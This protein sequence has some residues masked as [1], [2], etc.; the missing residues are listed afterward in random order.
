MNEERISLEQL[1][2]DN[3]DLE[4]LESLLE[5][6]NIFEVLGAVRQEVRHSDFLAFL[7]DPQQHHG[8]GG[9]FVKRFL[10][11][12]LTGV[13]QSSLPVTAIDLDIWS[14]DDL[15]VHREW[16]NIDILLVS[17]S[18]Q[19][20]VVIENKVY[21]QEHSNQL[22]RYRK[23]AAQHYPNHR[24]LFLFLTPEGEEPSDDNYLS[25]SYDL[26]CSLVENLAQSR[27][28][29]LGPDVRT[30]MQHYT[31]MLRRYILSESEID[32]LCRKIY[33]KHQKALDLIYE[34]KPDLQSD[35][36]ELVE[37]VIGETPGMALDHCS[38]S[39]IRFGLED[40]DIPILLQGQ[41][42]T[43]SKR[44]MLFEFLNDEQS[45]RLK[46]TIGPGPLEVRQKL[47]ALSFGEYPPL[48]TA[49]KA[50]GKQFNT[51]Y[52]REFL[53]KKD[54]ED[55]SL[56]DLE[57]KVR[58]HWEEFIRGDLEKIKAILRKQ[59]WLWEEE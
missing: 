22:Q 33:R 40:W 24:L 11:K 53:S 7:M 9:D 37:T 17:E 38:K 21:S 20:A 18:N 29:S 54:Y 27:E 42:W 43:R 48:K 3:P 52:L 47:H 28:A 14:L 32:E 10:Q 13:N 1:V 50:L 46:L 51:V 26:V 44:I 56:D 36:Q 49:F 19:M 25:V 16:H 59:D 35:L 5:Q 57:V 2:I 12:A 15:E 23:I 58:K 30:L 31:S 55:A 45:L 34:Y 6:F 4:R 8:L 39:Y 41:G